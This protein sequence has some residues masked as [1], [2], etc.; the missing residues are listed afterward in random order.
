MPKIKK[1]ADR[2][3]ATLAQGMKEFDKCV[4]SLE[5]K[6]EFMS[7]SNPAYVKES[8]IGGKQA[9]RLYD[10]YGFPLELTEELAGERGLT[11]DKNGFEEA[12]KEHREKSRV[13]AAGQFKGGLESHSQIGRAHV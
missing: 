7:K 9:F 1:E 4:T 10:T 5:R 13:L 2:F 8:V 12:F 3:E 6:N 11:V